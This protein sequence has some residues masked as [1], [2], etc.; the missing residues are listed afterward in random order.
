MPIHVKWDAQFDNVILFEF[1]QPW[2]WEDF[3]QAAVQSG[4]MRDERIAQ[5]PDADL[6]FYTIGD[7]R[8]SGRVPRGNGLMQVYGAV[9]RKYTSQPK[10]LI[11]ISDDFLMRSLVQMFNR[12]YG[13]TIQ[14]HTVSSLEE[15]Y[16]LIQQDQAQP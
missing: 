14:A 2:V 11:A 16:A 9:K 12:L 3:H 8:Q 4:N 15:A 6:T 1:I 7:F 5:H 10:M 13:H